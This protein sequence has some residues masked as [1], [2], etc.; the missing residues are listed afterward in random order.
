MTCKKTNTH[1]ELVLVYVQVC[2]VVSALVLNRL[3]ERGTLVLSGPL[4]T[5]RNSRSPETL[6][7]GHA[8]S[9][10]A[11]GKFVPGCSEATDA[12]LDRLRKP[13][14]VG[15]PGR[16]SGNRKRIE[17]L[18]AEKPLMCDNS[19]R[20]KCATFFLLCLCSS[21]AEFKLMFLFCVKTAVSASSTRNRK[22]LTCLNI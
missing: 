2:V 19:K 18:H 1:H 5:P 21:T 8:D 11:P 13:A 14:V 3:S 15:L 9:V 16:E 6:V 10:E 20:T 4:T 7:K 17:S 12:Q 22:Y